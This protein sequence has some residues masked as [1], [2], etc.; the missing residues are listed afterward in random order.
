VAAL[1]HG[2]IELPGQ[3]WGRRLIAR[4]PGTVGGLPVVARR[5]AR[6]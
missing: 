1:L 4:L 3:A 2:A 5:I 6:P